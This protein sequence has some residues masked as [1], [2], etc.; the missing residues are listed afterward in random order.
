MPY[1]TTTI[2]KSSDYLWAASIGTLDNPS[3]VRPAANI[4]VASAPAW[5]CFDPNLEMFEHQPP[6]PS[7]SGT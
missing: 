6:Q 4:W 7:K 1:L 2:A 3:S 5:A